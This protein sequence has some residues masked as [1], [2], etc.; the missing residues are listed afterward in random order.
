M[1]DVLVSGRANVLRSYYSFN[2]I[3]AYYVC[4][5]H[6]LYR[7]KET[8][9]NSGYGHALGVR[10]YSAYV[11]TDTNYKRTI[12]VEILETENCTF[13]FYD[14]CLTYANIP[15]TGSTNYDGYS[16]MDFVNNGLQ[17]TGDSN[18]VN[19]SNR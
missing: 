10:F 5:Y 9:F 11:P 19:Y 3:G 1:A 2:T 7:M 6:E 15:G 18:D 12:E 13:S 4:Y 14:N 16:E 8:G 17:E